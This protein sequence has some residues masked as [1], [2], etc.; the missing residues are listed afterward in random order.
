VL[1]NYDPVG[2]WREEWPKAKKKIDSAVVLP[3][4]TKVADAVALKRWLVQ[5]IDVF[6]QNFAEKLLTY[7]TGRRP[8]HAERAEIKRIVAENRRPT[9]G[10]RDLLLAL[11]AS[12]T[13]RIR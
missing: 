3:D 4:G 1:E 5:N 9:A 8:N 6:T 7:A 13:F 2:R 10:A 12:E 11:I